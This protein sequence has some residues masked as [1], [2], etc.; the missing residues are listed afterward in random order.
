MLNYLKKYNL[1][2][3]FLL[4]LSLYILGFTMIPITKSIM[5]GFQDNITGQWTL[6]VYEYL[7]S[8]PD[9]MRSIWNTIGV[10]IIGLTIQISL[11]L[12]VAIVLKQTFKGKS[13]IRALVLM[14]MGIPTLVSG[15][16]LLYVFGTQG[17][18]NELL[19]RIGLIE[20]PINWTSGNIQSL[21]VIAIADTWKVLPIVV[22]LLLAGLESISKD[23]YEASSI[24]GASKWHDFRYVT[25][26]LLKPAITMTVIL[27]AV[28]SF[29]IF[30]LP[31]I[32]VGKSVPFLSTYAYEEYAYNN[33]SA[34]GAA[35]TVLLVLILIFVMLYI[36]FVDKGEGLS[37]G[38]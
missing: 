17:Y 13:I 15:V 9:F 31:Q 34:S 19:Y 37:S 38:K 16:T 8:K 28:D 4:P 18:L 23:V 5:M 22:L 24:D 36:K 1:E 25:L 14:P 10:T 12:F 30:E 26:P 20:V 2:I 11:G 3:L 7:F 29:R 6:S 33:L 21:F 35:S 27:R 32:L